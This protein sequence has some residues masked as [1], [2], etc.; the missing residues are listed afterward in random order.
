[1]KPACTPGPVPEELLF[2]RMTIVFGLIAAGIAI[3]GILAAFFGIA[4]A[5]GAS[6]EY[7]TIALSAALI[8]TLLGTILTYQAIKIPG[9]IAGAAIQAILVIVTVSAA[10]E[11]LFSIQ[12]NHFFI[13]NYFVRLGAVILGPS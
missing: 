6:P 12:G 8:W 2:R 3:G 13:E 5:R 9:R 7:R 1:M 4:L 10:I 11:F